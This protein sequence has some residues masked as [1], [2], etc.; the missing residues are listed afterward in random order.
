[1]GQSYSMYCCRTSPFLPT[2]SPHITSVSCAP[3]S[4][5]VSRISS[6]MVGPKLIRFPSTRGLRRRSIRRSVLGPLE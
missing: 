3:S 5:P 6:T 2:A 4:L 1:M